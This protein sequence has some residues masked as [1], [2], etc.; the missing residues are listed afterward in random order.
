MIKTIIFDFGDVFINLDKPATFRELEKHNIEGFT[1]VI[2]KANLAYEKGLIS[3]NDFIKTYRSEYNKLEK[4]QVVDSWNAILMDF[5]EYRFR[6]IK[7]LSEEKDHQLI[8]LSNTNEIHIDHVKANVPFFEE[9]K[10]C[11]DAFYLSYEINYRK[12]DAAIYKFVLEKHD[13]NPNECLFIDDTYENTEAAASLGI[14]VWN[15]EPT[16]EDVI[17]LFTTKKDLF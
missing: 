7:K 16:R 12:P 6:F 11:F 10:N 9:F 1:E 4:K 13:L 2:K 14:H 3:S 8:L 5:P 15:L 17:D